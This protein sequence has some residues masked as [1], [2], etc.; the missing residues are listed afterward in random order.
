MTACVIKY[1]CADCGAVFDEPEVK[2]WKEYHDDGWAEDWAAYLCPVCGSE[3]V[4]EREED[5][6]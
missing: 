2:R 3:E 5:Y 6:G 4:D 1:V